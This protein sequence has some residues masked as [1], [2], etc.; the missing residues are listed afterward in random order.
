MRTIHYLLTL[1]LSLLVLSCQDE[2]VISLKN[3]ELPSSSN[4]AT[5]AM[6]ITSGL[7]Q[8]ENGYWVASRRIPLVGKGR[9]VD[10]IS[11]ALVSVLGWKENIGHMVDTDIENSASFAGAA[12]VQLVG[13]QIAS[14]RDMTRTY[15]GNQTAGFVYKVADTGLLTLNVLKGFW[16]ETLWKGETQERKG[17][18]TEATTLELNLLSAANNDGKQ[19]L[20]I[21]TSFDKPFDEVRIGMAGVSADVLKSLTLYY[22]FVG[23]N[24][25]QACTTDNTTYFPDGVEIHKNGVFDL[26]WTSLVGAD[27]I[28]NSDLTDGAGFSVVGGLLS[29][30]HVTVN[31]K[32]PIAKGT[33]VGFCFTDATILDISLLTGTVLE[34]YDANDDLVDKVTINSLLGLSAIGGGKKQVSL[35]ASKPCTQVRIK[36]TGVNINLGATVVNY[37]FVREPVIVDA[38]SYLS[39][40][41]TTISGSSYQFPAPSAGTMH[42]TLMSAPSGVVPQMTENNRLTGMTVDGDYTVMV[43]YT[44]IDGETYSQTVVITRKTKKMDGEGCNTLIT[45]KANNVELYTPKGGGSLISISDIDGVQNIIDDNPDNYATYTKGITVAGNIG[46]LGIQ[47]KDAS[48]LNTA[49]RKIRIG[50]TVQ[51]KAQFLGADALT[52]FRI[53]MKRNGAYID[54]GVTDENNAISAGLIGDDGSRMR[55][56]LVT[57]KDFDA[58]ELWNSGLLTL[59]VQLETF[60]IYNA[61]WEPAES[62]CYSGSVGDACLEL[63][64]AANH[65]AEINYDATGTGAVASVGSSFNNLGNLLDDNRESATMITNTTV[66]G[67]VTLAVKFNTIRT[68][69]QVGFMLKGISGLADVDLLNHM[70]LSVYSAGVKD[71]NTKTSWGVVGAEVIGAGDYTYIATIPQVTE[72]DEVRI[73][74]QGVGQVLENVQ[75]SGVFIRPDTD[76][77]GVPDC[78]EENTDDNRNPITNITAAAHTCQG[79]FV[80]LHLEGE[81][82]PSGD[83]ILTFTDVTGTNNVADKTLALNGN[84]LTIDNLPAGDYYINVKSAANSNAYYN[85]VHVTV[86]PNETTWTPRALS[87]AWD[88]WNNWSNGMPWDCTNVIIPDSNT[89]PILQKG[90]DYYCAGI[91]FEPGAEVVNTH[92]LHYQKAWVELALAPGRYYMLSAPLTDWLTGDLFIPASMNGLHTGTK[93]TPLNEGNSPENRFNPRIFQRLWSANAEGKKLSGSVSV[94]PDETNW[95]PPFNAVGQKYSLGMGYSMLVDKG[96]LLN[97]RFVF[98]FPKTHHEYSYYNTA[99]TVVGTEMVSRSAYEGRFIYEQA[100]VAPAFPFTVT[101]KNQKAGTTFLVGNPFM[102]HIDIEKFIAANPSITSIKVYDGNNN[103]SL[104][105]IGGELVANGDTYS[106]IAPM[107]SFFVTVGTPATELQ[108]TFNEEMQNQL[109]GNEGMLLS[110]RSARSRM[111]RSASAIHARLGITATSGRVS[112][113][114][115]LILNPQASAAYVSGEDAELLLDNEVPPEIAVFSVAD[116][117]ALDIQQTNPRVTRIPLGFSLKTSGHVTFTLSH[118]LGDGWEAW[119]LLDTQTGRRYPLTDYVVKV[120]AGIIGTH[121]GRFWLEKN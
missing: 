101:V 14:V 58:I 8:D 100:G 104:I 35:I 87:T 113:N 76:G 26:G 77:D 10:N 54:S 44:T 85:G 94:V 2:E 89:Y 67:G 32:T 80:E 120:D 20:S 53:R 107:Q 49:G 102:T 112:A 73:T 93:F 92:Y 28:I 3:N 60:R 6:G 65:G 29:D 110:T 105:N 84:K 91:H 41:N 74:F 52:F 90:R 30:P 17:G 114:A 75:V 39:L 9:I 116:G 5:R 78:A 118:Q 83:Y 70:T 22:A 72:F 7:T 81:N 99:G 66:L 97:D 82:L 103:N 47:T 19:A 4:P 71:N 42:C 48:L 27:K 15:A 56:S 34:T 108:I 57:D 86:H 23:D 64:T 117:K 88:D 18:N 111:T 40:S 62:T 106:H 24:P 95:T 46:I 50:F 1:A 121:A 45:A 115:L 109:P 21:S 68:K 12:N 55:L 59:N 79:E 43:T 98:R 16:I 96:N 51:P 36:F 11:D 38:S 33:E 31:F 13:N 69:A 37:A 25:V 119:S 61:F 63:L